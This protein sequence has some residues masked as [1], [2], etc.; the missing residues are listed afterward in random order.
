MGW[1]DVQIFVSGDLTEERIKALLA[2]GGRADSFGV[3]TALSTSADSPSVGVIYKLVEVEFAN[4][5]RDM[6]KFSAEK[7]TYP[8]RKQVFRFSTK[9]GMFSADVIALEDEMFPG[10]EPLLVQ[11]MQKGRR[12]EV[13]SRSPAVTARNARSTFLAGRKR[14]HPRFLTL[15][16]A[17]PFPVRYSDRLEKLCDQI[18]HIFVEAASGPPPRAS[19]GGVIVQADIA[20]VDRPESFQA[21]ITEISRPKMKPAAPI[22]AA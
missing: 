2:G 4:H 11:V 22:A 5:I 15:G 17:T 19:R 12:L 9:E 13:A 6:A 8:G 10:A 14:L 20:R 16:S 18:R 3:G 1:T 21:L 7:K